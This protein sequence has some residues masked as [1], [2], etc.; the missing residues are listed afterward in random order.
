MGFKIKKLGAAVKKVAPAA[1]LVAGGV[2][3]TMAYQKLA[4]IA[5][6]VMQKKRANDRAS[7]QAALFPSVAPQP[8]SPAYNAPDAVRASAGVDGYGRTASGGGFWDFLAK[9]FGGR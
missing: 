6:D 4:P 8:A 5:K 3:G 7:E 9:L 2:A 1:A